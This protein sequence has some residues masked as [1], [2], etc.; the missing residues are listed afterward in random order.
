MIRINK[1]IPLLIVAPFLL[2]GLSFLVLQKLLPFVSH[3]V[4]YCKSIIN[5][6]SLSIPQHI[7]II[8]LILILLFIIGVVV[9]LC[10][11][12]VRVQLMKSTLIKKRISLTTF[13]ILLEKLDLVNKTHFIKSEKR[14]AFC[15]GIRSP[16][17]YIST[18]LISQ[19]SKKEIEAVLR[20]EQY[21]L[22]NHDTL[23]MIIASVSHSL[24][25][26]FPLLGDLINKYRVEREIQADKFAVRKI[27]DSYPLISALKKL[28]SFPTFEAAA[29][30]SIAD[31]DTLEP[32]IY[33]LI[34]KEISF[35]KE[36][37]LKHIA[38][39]ILS[40]FVIGFIIIAPVRAFEI[41]NEGENVM[42]LCPH[43][44]ECVIVCQQGYMKGQKN[45]SGNKLFSPSK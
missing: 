32:R 40:L 36:F 2:G 20:H 6:L 33:A 14:F 42:M 37:Q 15:L 35:K 30:A 21:H 13:S 44:E 45:Y 1:S 31:K 12:Y 19:L 26:F 39:S 9:K 7:T 17:I 11:T 29:V 34:K 41:H 5:A 4:Y 18:G 22:E 28:L 3:T 27:G 10:I 38:V 25:P 8:P 16:K 43:G 23:T 24:F